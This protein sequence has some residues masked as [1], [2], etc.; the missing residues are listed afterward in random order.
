MIT[1]DSHLND[2]LL[3]SARDAGAGA[4]L[5]GHWGDQ[6]LFEQAYLIDLF[7]CGAWRTLAAHL[8]EYPEWFPGEDGRYFRRRLW[9]DFLQ[10]DVPRRLQRPMRA[11][12]RAWKQPPL[13]LDWYTSS[14][15]A[16][17][18]PDEFSRELTGGTPSALARALYREVRSRYHGLCLEWHAKMAAAHGMDAGEG[19]GRGLCDC[20]GDCLDCFA[21]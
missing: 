4:I 5:T 1:R 15:R 18:G 21:V 14:F 3:A 8:R 17:I 7:H 12:R 9:L 13:W 6:M 2:Q 19:S 16:Q 20:G 10:Y 11:I